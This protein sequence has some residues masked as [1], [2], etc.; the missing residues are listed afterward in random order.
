MA[1]ARRALDAAVAAGAGF[2][3]LG[4]LTWLSSGGLLRS[5]EV[6]TTDQ[7]E[8]LEIET[9]TKTEVTPGESIGEIS[10]PDPSWKVVSCLTALA[11]SGASVCLNQQGSNAWSCPAPGC[12]I[13]PGQKYQTHVTCARIVR[14]EED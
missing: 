7:L 2:V 14:Q 4:V 9:F 13:V 6:A 12:T 3:V 5:L 1:I 10:C 8:S 11:P